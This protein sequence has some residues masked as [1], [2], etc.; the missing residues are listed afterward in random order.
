MPLSGAQSAAAVCTATYSLR[1]VG[2]GTSRLFFTQFTS[3]T[4]PDLLSAGDF[5]HCIAALCNV[6]AVR[7]TQKPLATSSCC[8]IS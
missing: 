3:L 4:S 1:S 7:L 6:T 2:G 8:A 5:G